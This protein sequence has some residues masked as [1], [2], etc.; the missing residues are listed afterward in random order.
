MQWWKYI[1]FIDVPKIQ[2]KTRIE[3]GRKGYYNEMIQ[4]AYGKG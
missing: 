3:R 1:G 2:E 4:G